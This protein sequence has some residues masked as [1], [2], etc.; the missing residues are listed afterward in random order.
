MKL[1]RNLIVCLSGMLAFGMHATERELGS[2]GDRMHLGL[3][4]EFRC[5]KTVPITI[6]TQS[7]AYF[8]QDAA[9]IQSIVVNTAGAILGFECQ[10]ADKI[11]FSVTRMTF[12]SFV[13]TQKTFEMGDAELPGTT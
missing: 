1:L 2:D 12:L 4:A 6:R 10:S 13:L 8:D 3:N 7:A 9:K 11:E 5:Q